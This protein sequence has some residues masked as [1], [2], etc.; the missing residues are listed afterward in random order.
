MTPRREEMLGSIQSKIGAAL[1]R[2]KKEGEK[3]KERK[4]ENDFLMREK[5][6]KKISL[7]CYSRL[8]KMVVYYSNVVK[9]FNYDTTDVAC[10]L[11]FVVLKIA[12]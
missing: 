11:L 7:C 3:T 4:R 5:R 9:I 6:D 10:I 1:E 12:I 8:P 2:R